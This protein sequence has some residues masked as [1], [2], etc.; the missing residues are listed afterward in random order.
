[1]ALTFGFTIGNIYMMQSLL[2]GEIF[3]LR[4][5]ATVMGVVVLAGQVGSGAG[6]VF[7]GWYH[8]VTGG[9]AAPF[10]VLGAVNLAAAVVISFARPLRE[11]RARPGRSTAAA[12]ACRSL[13]PWRHLRSWSTGERSATS[14]CATPPASTPATG[15]LY[16]SCFTD[17]LRIDFS[18][19]THR[20]APAE[21]ISADDWV[22]MVRSTISGFESTQ[23]LIANHVITFDGPDEG[24]YTAY[25][26]AQH[27]MDR[28]RWY[29]I[30]GWYENEVRRVDGEWRIA[31]LHA[32]PDLGRRRP[33][34]PGR[35]V[36]CAR[37]RAPSGAL[38]H[39]ATLRRSPGS[40]RVDGD[41]GGLDRRPHPLA[42]AQR[43]RAA[44]LPG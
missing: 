13:R 31:S 20:P 4:S 3:G 39:A 17:T 32:A 27:W 15:P 38:N 10:H 14:R 24:R 1:M 16:R 12:V 44:A 2:V 25:L 33:V 19:F 36:R 26:Q 6:L 7:M 11:P 28:D 8:D 9:Y 29:L 34:A 42:A 43:E 37:R 35:P 40:G 18:S 41:L 21:P 22:G 30:G 23:H 5:F